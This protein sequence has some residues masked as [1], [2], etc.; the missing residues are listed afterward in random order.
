MKKGVQD[1]IPKWSILH[2]EECLVFAS[3][4]RHI[5]QMRDMDS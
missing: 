3:G 5:G 1:A 4:I 2:K